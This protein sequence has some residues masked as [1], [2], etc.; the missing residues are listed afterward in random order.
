VKKDV[1]KDVKEDV[2]EDVAD[3]VVEDVVE[4]VADQ[5]TGETAVA[6]AAVPQVEK[7]PESSTVLSQ[8]IDHPSIP[9]NSNSSLSF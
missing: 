1:K 5:A 8:D 4:D 7:D 2:K 3:N 6:A 9:T